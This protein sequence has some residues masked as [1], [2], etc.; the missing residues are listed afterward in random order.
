MQ[1]MEDHAAPGARWALG[2]QEVTAPPAGGERTATLGG[3]A[4]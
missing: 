3:T 4:V 1:A 2:T